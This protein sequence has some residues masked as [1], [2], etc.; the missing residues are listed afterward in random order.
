MNHDLAAALKAVLS[1]RFLSESEA[2]SAMQAMLSTDAKPEQIGAFLTAFHFRA[3]NAD[4]LTGFAR[5]LRDK[6][7]RF[8]LHGSDKMID[9]CGTGGDGHGT[10]NVSTTVAFVVAGAGVPVAKH[11]NRSVSS[12]SGSFDV[13][14]ALGA[15]TAREEA[16]ARDH[17]SDLG[18][19]FL[20]APT[21]H[22]ALKDLGPLRRNLGFRTIF[23][24][25]GPLLNPVGVKRQLIGVFSS[26]LLEPAAETLR[27]LGSSNAMIVHGED[28]SDEI[29]LAGPTQI[30]HLREGRLVPLTITPE[31]FGLSRAPIDAIRGG[32]AAENARILERILNGERGAPRDIVVMN[33]AAALLIAG[34]VGTFTEGVRA[35]ADAID[36]GHALT[37][38][39]R[40]Q[41]IA[42]P[43]EQRVMP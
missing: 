24:A 15:A 9:V 10:F 42:R 12:R 37:V 4:E 41:K 36:S 39:R 22:P 40:S 8:D 5:L 26:R 27:R 16:T 21:F 35:A 13:L 1:G 38:L 20:F 3:P 32:D 7:I 14:E 19:A 2:A 11:G 28:S 17:L 33:A 6:A 29:S 43:I 34:R 23:N 25:L 31:D 18:L 30:V